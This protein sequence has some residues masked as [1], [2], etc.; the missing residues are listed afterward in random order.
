M[1]I[2]SPKGWKREEKEEKK[3]SKQQTVRARG[4][5]KGRI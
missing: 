1:K 3:K 2:G 5:N 4:G